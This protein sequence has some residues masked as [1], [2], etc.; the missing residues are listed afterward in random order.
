M[1]YHVCL[2]GGITLLLLLLCKTP[3]YSEMVFSGGFRY[4]TFTNDGASQNVG[5]EVTIPLG[6]LYKQERFSISLETAY[7]EAKV[8]SDEESDAHIASMTD[9]L[10]SLS[11]RHT[12]SKFQLGLIAGVDFNFPTGTERLRKNQRKA[13]VGES[14]DLFE[15]DNFG[16]GF[17]VGLN[18]G[19]M[20]RFKQFSVGM[21]GAYIFSG[22]YD[23]THD[24]DQDTLD[25]GDQALFLS[26][27][28]WKISD[29]MTMESLFSYSYF[30]ADT[31]NGTKDFQEGERFVL[32]QSFRFEAAPITV[33]LSGQAA[34][35]ARNTVLFGETFSIEPENS[36]GNEFFGLMHVNY[37]YND[38]LRLQFVGDIRYYEE[39]ERMDKLFNLPF[40]G[41]RIRY[42]CGPGVTFI[43]G[44]RITWYGLVK[45][46]FMDQDRDRTLE[47]ALSFHGV[48][49]SLGLMYTF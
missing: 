27:L 17:N 42:A 26:F 11:Y 24:V 48:N 37:S 45:Y 30:T 43:S 40:Q 16:E 8:E 49:L 31:T 41:K 10:L 15:V 47:Q 33:T 19:V 22:E 2:R 6:L 21:H 3:I 13:E 36:N 28:N 9:T 7:S 12:F 18:L 32:A 35:Q 39:S 4:D 25:P 44:S 29:R 14:N 23:P 5:T 46:F 34:F 38:N 1:K 20:K